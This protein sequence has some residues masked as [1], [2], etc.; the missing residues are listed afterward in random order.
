MLPSFKIIIDSLLIWLLKQGS[1]GSGATEHLR[2]HPFHAN[3]VR[4]TSEPWRRSK[5]H[6][7]EEHCGE[8]E[9]RKRFFFLKSQ[10]EGIGAVNP[11]RWRYIVEDFTEAFVSGSAEWPSCHALGHGESQLD[12]APQWWKDD[13]QKDTQDVPTSSVNFEALGDAASERRHVRRRVPCSVCACMGWETERQYVFMWKQPQ[14]A[15]EK[16]FIHEDAVYKRPDKP[17]GEKTPRE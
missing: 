13:E 5:K 11:E 3:C 12:A 8:S 15:A 10:I 1:C 16:S 17:S 7:D 9:Y 14:D 6:L 4:R 2:C